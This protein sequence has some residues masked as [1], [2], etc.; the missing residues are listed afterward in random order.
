MPKVSIIV[1]VYNVEKYLEKC[2]DSLINQ[3][4]KDIE[5]I[6][7]NDGSK[8]N[9]LNI[10]EEYSK[11][12]NRIIIIN[13]YNAGV[14]VARNSGID[15]AK[16]EYI[17]FV[18]SDDWV[19][20]DFYEKLYNSAIKNDADIAVAGI[21]RTK[22]N[23]KTFILEY[24]DK[25]VTNNIYRKIEL[26]DIP[27]CCF[28]VNKIYKLDKLKNLN[29]KFETNRI[30][31]DM[32]WTPQI[33]Y[34]MDKI[35]TVSDTYYYYWRHS[36]TL[37]K[38]SNAKTDEDLKYA[39][40]KFESFFKGRNVN[41]DKYLTKIKK[42]Q[43]FGVTLLKIKQKGY[44]KEYKLFNFIKY[45]WGKPS[46]RGNLIFKIDKYGKRKRI[47]FPLGLN[48]RF[49]GKNSIV[50]IHEPFPIFKRCKIVLGDNCSVVIGSSSN[51]ISKLKIYA[52]AEYS[53][54]S[55]GR[56]C[57][58]FGESEIILRP[59]PNKIVS[60]GDNCMVGKNLQIRTS[61]AHSVVDLSNNKPINHAKSVMIGDHVWLGYDVTILKGVRIANDCII[62][63]KSLVTRDCSKS[64]SV[65]VGIPANKVKENVTWDVKNP[66]S[67]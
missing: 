17:G 45:G 15:I 16:G 65:Y 42:Y 62:G 22:K 43:I 23:K 66:A 9:S 44:K 31:E 59:E 54:C 2:L 53:K 10:L 14:S 21:I 12:D 39:K 37:V 3:T 51:R 30:Y 58:F 24:N 64:N 40:E 7:V 1:P 28:V 36:N 26:C 52:N 27:E 63:T 6:C 57:F 8:D 29:I 38:M 47:Y 56:N 55:I 46:Y 33:L 11:N 32:V 4:L 50:T 60:I 41:I 35:V 13:Q 48:I 5:I 19:D 49:K 25:E 34:G 67:Y 61:D 20:L 18:D